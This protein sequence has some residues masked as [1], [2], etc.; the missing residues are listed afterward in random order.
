MPSADQIKALLKAYAQGNDA[1]FHSV[2]MQIA[3]GEAR[4]GHGKLAEEI[5]ELVDATE[6][7]F[8]PVERHLSIGS[9][10]GRGRRA[11]DS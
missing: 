1:Q 2:A 8:Q 6:F 5:R 11:F 7:E 3:A 9:S 4:M 10:Q